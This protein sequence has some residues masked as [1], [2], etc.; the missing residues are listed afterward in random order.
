[1]D[2]PSLCPKCGVL[3]TMRVTVAKDRENTCTQCGDVFIDATSQ[4]EQNYIGLFPQEGDAGDAPFALFRDASTLNGFLRFL[5]QH[6]TEE[7]TD[8]VPL[9]SIDMRCS[10]YGAYWNSTDTD[11]WEARFQHFVPHALEEYALPSFE[12]RHKLGVETLKMQQRFFLES[13]ESP[14][15]FCTNNKR[16]YMFIEMPDGKLEAASINDTPGNYERVYFSSIYGAMKLTARS[17]NVRSP[18]V[19][20][21]EQFTS[22][23]GTLALIDLSQDVTPTGND[24]PIEDAGGA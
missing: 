7:E 13:D 20:S 2:R 4:F 8:R 9:D 14:V 23:G 22:K 18:V 16:W 10:V 19:L 21:W 1:M 24:F 5:K 11:P 17:G 15:Y 6:A 3:C 12:V